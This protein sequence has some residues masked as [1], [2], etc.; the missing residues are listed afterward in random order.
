VAESL[1]DQLDR[2]LGV[3][4]L[5]RT[6]LGGRPVVV[7]GVAEMYWTRLPYHPTDLD[8]CAP[9]DADVARRLRD[10][11]FVKEG[12]HWWHETHGVA[13]EFPAS[14]ADADPAR[15]VEADGALVIGVADL[16]L[17]RLRQS[18]ANDSSGSVEHQSLLAVASSCIDIIDWPYVRA[19]IAAEPP[20]L[21]E[22][23]RHNDR[24]VRRAVR[25]GLRRLEAESG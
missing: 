15:V 23:M 12:R 20:H 4:A 10:A 1:S 6:V 16:Y 18:T 3:A 21:R 17:D 22:R 25:Q 7:G 19:R 14:E 9:V 2:L 11:G 13:V 8:V 24:A 5:L